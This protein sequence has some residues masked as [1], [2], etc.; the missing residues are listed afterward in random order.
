MTRRGL[1]SRAGVSVSTVA[2][3][4]R[5]AG[6][7]RLANAWKLTQALGCTLDDV[8]RRGETEG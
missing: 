4:E 2:R 6:A 1:A 8:V 7:I 5:D 3:F